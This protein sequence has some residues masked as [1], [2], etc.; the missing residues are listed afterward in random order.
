MLDFKEKPSTN[1]PHSIDTAQEKGTVTITLYR[2]IS[3]LVGMDVIGE[4]RTQ[5]AAEVW[6]KRSPSSQ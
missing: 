6:A 3:F 5:F 4:I 1:I 2:Q